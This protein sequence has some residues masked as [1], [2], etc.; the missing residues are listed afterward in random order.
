VRQT[1]GLLRDMGIFVRLVEMQSV[2]EAARSLALPKSTVSRRLDA[3][4]ESLGVRLVQ[5][6]NRGLAVTELGT[7]YYQRAR[8]VLGLAE[9]AVQAVVGEERLQGTLR[10]TAP[11]AV[12]TLIVS[13]VLSGFLREHPEVSAELLLTDRRVDLA[14][15][16]FDLAVRVEAEAQAPEGFE[17]QALS[18]TWIFLC[19]SPAYVARR[20]L[21][22]KPADL[23]GHDAVL[24]TFLGGRRWRLRGPGGLVEVDMAGRLTVNDVTMAERGVRAGLGIAPIAAALA[25]PQVR[26]GRLVHLLEPWT[27]QVRSFY[28]VYPV[29]GRRPARTQRLIEHMVTH[30]RS[31]IA[32]RLGPESAPVPP[33]ER[34]VPPPVASA[35]SQPT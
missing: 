28:A 31:A 16:R 30:L 15:G 6:N 24:V 20:G 9:E 10:V 14:E 7:A 13:E 12:G 22:Q 8:R 19:A 32:E 4:E 33:V 29:E 23:E 27:F 3:L 26:A 5:R 35:D 34:H 2:T 18:P 21:P 11:R 17:T 25:A 1:G